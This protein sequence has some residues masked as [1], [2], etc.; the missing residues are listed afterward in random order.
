MTHKQNLQAVSEIL[1]K[2]RSDDEL[3]GGQVFIGAGDFRQI[4]PIIKR[5]SREDTVR[6]SVNS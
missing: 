1:Q 5:G 6:A 3:F 2:V 4:P